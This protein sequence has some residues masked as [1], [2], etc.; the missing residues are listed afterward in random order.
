ML[1]NYLL[2]YSEQLATEMD[3]T[4]FTKLYETQYGWIG[5]IGGHEFES[6]YYIT[7]NQKLTSKLLG[8]KLAKADVENIMNSDGGIR[9]ETSNFNC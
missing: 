6:Y 4:N 9:C 3:K 2:I 5:R 1:K 8:I 7:T